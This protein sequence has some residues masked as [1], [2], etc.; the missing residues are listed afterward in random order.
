MN[1]TADNAHVTILE[2][3]LGFGIDESTKK[4]EHRISFTEQKL[5]DRGM[6]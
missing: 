4:V 1:A 2:E 3:S 6:G 5:I